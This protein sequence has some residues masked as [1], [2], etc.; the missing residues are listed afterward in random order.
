MEGL[1]SRLETLASVLRPRQHVLTLANAEGGSGECL[2]VNE[3]YGR[4]PCRN[5]VGS[6]VTKCVCVSSLGM[7]LLKCLKIRTIMS[8]I[9]SS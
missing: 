2:L 7:R 1:K 6:S 9:V 4:R 5:P 3:P 8:G